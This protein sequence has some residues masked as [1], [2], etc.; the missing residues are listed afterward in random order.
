MATTTGNDDIQIHQEN[1][2]DNDNANVDIPLDNTDRNDTTILWHQEQ[3]H[4]F[5]GGFYLET[6]GPR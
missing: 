1:D 6:G 2:H 3:G 4:H 5:S